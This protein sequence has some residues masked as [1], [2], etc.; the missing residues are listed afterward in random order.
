MKIV[1]R[2]WLIV[3]IDEVKPSDNCFLV[4]KLKEIL[5]DS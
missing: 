2:I 1:N 3:V 4:K 5:I